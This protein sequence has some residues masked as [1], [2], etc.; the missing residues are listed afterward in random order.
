MSRK[1]RT[2]KVRSSK[3][4]SSQIRDVRMPLGQYSLLIIGVV[5]VGILLAINLI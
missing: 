4:G 3:K 5:V 2:K 1:A